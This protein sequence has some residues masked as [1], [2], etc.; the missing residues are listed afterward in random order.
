MKKKC[1]KQTSR[2]DLQETLAAFKKLSP[3]EKRNAYVSVLIQM[4]G[5]ER[6]NAALNRQLLDSFVTITAWDAETVHTLRKKAETL[7]G[8]TQATAAP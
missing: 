6:N 7:S 3:Q 5:K 4:R 1:A 2:D 8:Q